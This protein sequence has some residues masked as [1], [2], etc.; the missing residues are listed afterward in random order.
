MRN[1]KE[2]DWKLLA[3]LFKDAKRS[4]RELA[5]I[6]GT[7]QPTV[8]RRR[9]RLEKEVIESYT[10]IPKWGKIGYEIF[11]ITLVKSKPELAS[12]EKYNESRKKGYDWLLKQPNVMMAGG[13]RG[14]R[15]VNS[16]MIS[17][18]KN[19]SDYDDFMYRYRLEWGPHI[20]ETETILVNLVGREL[21]KPLNLKYL[22]E[23][24]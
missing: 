2:F 8:S 24:T 11:A 23:A 16:F 15:G 3:E 22:A 19:F 6:F 13:C 20:D 12:R 9:A 14:E 18:H 7:S 4:D 21:L 10:V 1:K 5:R 17:L